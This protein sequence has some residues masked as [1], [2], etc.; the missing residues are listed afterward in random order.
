MNGFWGNSPYTTTSIGSGI[1]FVRILRT[2]VIVILSETTNGSIWNE[3]KLKV[4]IVTLGK[5]NQFVIDLK[6][7]LDDTSKKIVYVS[8]D[9][10]KVYSYKG[11]NK[12]GEWTDTI[13]IHKRS[14]STIYL[15]KVQMERIISTIRDFHEKEKY[16]YVKGLPHHF[17]MLL[18]GPPGSG[19]TSLILALASY[20]DVHI[21]YLHSSELKYIQ[22]ASTLLPKNAWLVIEDI[23][24]ND[25]THVRTSNEQVKTEITLDKKT[26]S[27]DDTKFTLDSVLN[28]WDGLLASEGRVLIITTNHPEKLDPALTRPGRVDLIEEIGFVTDEAAT[29]FVKSFYDVD[30]EIRVKTET[31][32]SELQNAVLVDKLSF[33]E[34]KERFSIS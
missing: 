20:F 4:R 34:F 28:C 5:N 2:N 30:E 17:G 33:S 18:S 13:T 31:V 3:D 14:L 1:H 19:K 16:H 27:L 25:V 29:A 6:K 12:F 15:P 10:M 26:L 23:D 7:A 22:N 21:C 24:S 11:D 32:V 8:D 9:K